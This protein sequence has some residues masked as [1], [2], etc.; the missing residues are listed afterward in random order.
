MHSIRQLIQYGII[1]L[2]YVPT[3]EQVANKF[4]GI[5]KISLVMLTNGW[6]EGI[7]PLGVTLSPPPFTY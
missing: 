2:E 7:F 1:S 3:K 6:N 5:T 4:L